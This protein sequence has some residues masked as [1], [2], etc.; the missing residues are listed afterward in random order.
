MNK[1]EYFNGEE[2]KFVNNWPNPDMAWASLGDDNLNY[3]VVGSITGLVHYCNKEEKKI[4][5]SEQKPTAD[6]T[7]P[8]NRGDLFFSVMDVDEEGGVFCDDHGFPIY[9]RDKIKWWIDKPILNETDR[10][11]GWIKKRVEL[12]D[13]QEEYIRFILDQQQN[14][15]RDLK[16]IKKL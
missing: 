4:L 2:W 15:I 16:K 5:F 6:G 7:Y 1:L 8:T 11:I 10:N 3:R 14:Q 9:S 12:S 13:L